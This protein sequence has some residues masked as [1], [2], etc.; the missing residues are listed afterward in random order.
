MCDAWINV[1]G[2]WLYAGPCRPGDYGFLNALQHFFNILT[3]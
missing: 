2:L 3:N 1:M